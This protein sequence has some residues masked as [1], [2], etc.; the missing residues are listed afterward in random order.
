MDER[1]RL[2][3]PDGGYAGFLPFAAPAA[4]ADLV[5]GNAQLAVGHR[6]ALAIKTAH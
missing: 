3:R 6:A 5:D 1:L 4:G 2:D